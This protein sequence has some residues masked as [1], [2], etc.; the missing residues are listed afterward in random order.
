MEDWNKGYIKTFKGEF[1]FIQTSDGKNEIFFH[2]S[3]IE[4][5]QNI[6]AGDFVEYILNRNYETG[7][8]PKAFKLR[9]LDSKQYK[10]KKAQNKKLRYSFKNPADMSTGLH[11]IIENFEIKAH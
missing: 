6:K 3:A 2:K 1:G 7:K 4:K 5:K 11:H 9:L 8:K 10:S